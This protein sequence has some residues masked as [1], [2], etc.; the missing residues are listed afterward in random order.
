M[1]ENPR[2]SPP[3]WVLSADGRRA[4]HSS[5]LVMHSVDGKAVA[6]PEGVEAMRVRMI[7]E[8]GSDRRLGADL[9]GLAAQ[10][11]RLFAMRAHH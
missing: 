1:A 3:G 6:D 8:L 11:E 7:E 9:Y 4:T 10:A 5:G 2:D